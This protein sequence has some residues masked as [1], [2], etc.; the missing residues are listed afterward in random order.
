MHTYAYNL[1]AT[2]LK[3]ICYV[4]LLSLNELSVHCVSF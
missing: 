4:T 3:N 2:I 1:D